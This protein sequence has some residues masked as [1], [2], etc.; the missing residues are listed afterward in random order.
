MQGYASRV[1]V[2]KIIDIKKKNT[3]SVYTS[4]V[5]NHKASEELSETGD[6]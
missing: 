4:R 3:V 6:V 1:L 2:L 5:H